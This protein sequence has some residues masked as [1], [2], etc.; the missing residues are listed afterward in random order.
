M[1]TLASFIVLASLLCFGVAGAAEMGPRDQAV[2]D[3]LTP[4]LQKEVKSR[5][6]GGNTVRGVLETILLNK[7]SNLFATNRI[8]AVDFEEGVAIVERA[9][10]NLET[11]YFSSTTLEIKPR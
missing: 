7:I 3:E 9:D 6:T 10:G 2:Y 8:Q 11:V 4:Q 5:L 1:R